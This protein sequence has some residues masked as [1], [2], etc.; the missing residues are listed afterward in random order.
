MD[1]RSRVDF[2]VRIFRVPL[3]KNASL[4]RI[5]R[6]FALDE[7]ES[8]ESYPKCLHPFFTFDCAELMWRT[9]AIFSISRPQYRSDESKERLR[10]S[11][12]VPMTGY[13]ILVSTTVVA[14]GSVKAILAFLGQNTTANYLDWTLAVLITS[15]SVSPLSPSFLLDVFINA[16]GC[17]I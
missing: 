6:I 15:L 9:L 17:I 16:L 1:C 12:F 14:I 5:P 3:L 8:K 11:T 13:R 7:W 10:N 2:T 4:R